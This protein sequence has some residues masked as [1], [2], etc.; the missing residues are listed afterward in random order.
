MMDRKAIV[1]VSGG[2]DSVVLLVHAVKEYGAANVIPVTFM[3]G[4]RAIY[5][6]SHVN[7]ICKLYGVEKTHFINL[8]G[9]FKHDCSLINSGS[10]PDD[11]LPFGDIWEL[12]LRNIIFVLIAASNGCAFR[13]DGS[14]FDILLGIIKPDPGGYV[15][16]DATYNSVIAMNTLLKVTTGV[17]C[18]VRAPFHSMS[19]S[20]V[21]NYGRSLDVPFELTYSCYMDGSIPCG[22][23]GGCVDRQKAFSEL[24]I[25]DPYIGG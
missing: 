17:H 14:K 13:R 20:D 10:I 1:L 8:F 7:D 3:Y 12:P 25:N 18:R 24:G 6:V 21:I 2:I 5:E 22:K 9:A 16:T 19:K 11:E 23:C 15:P 4:Q